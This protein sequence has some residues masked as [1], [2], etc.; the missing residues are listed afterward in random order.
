MDSFFNLAYAEHLQY[1]E[2]SPTMRCT[3]SSDLFIKIDLLEENHNY[4]ND[5]LELQNEFLPCSMAQ[6]KDITK[7]YEL[8]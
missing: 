2:Y 3:C 6:I 5:T 7:I 4:K 8:N 1:R